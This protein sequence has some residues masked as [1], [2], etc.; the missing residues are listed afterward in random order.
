[1]APAG[2]GKLGV[3]GRS[4]T[5]T[6][7]QV[8]PLPVRPDPEISAVTVSHAA[9]AFIPAMAALFVVGRVTFWVGYLV[10]PTARAFGMVLTGLPTIGAYGW[11]VVDAF[12]GRQG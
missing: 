9:L 6:W 11:L 10:Y 2:P 8:C 3:G 7:G 4:C 1:M 5:A 12:S